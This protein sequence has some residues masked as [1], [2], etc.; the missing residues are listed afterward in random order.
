MHKFYAITPYGPVGF[1]KTSNAKTRDA[2]RKVAK[3]LQSERVEHIRSLRGSVTAVTL[4][5]RVPGYVRSV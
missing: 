5:E 3:R 4:A 2:V 1:R